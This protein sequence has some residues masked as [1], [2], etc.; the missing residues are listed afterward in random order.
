[1]PRK[2]LEGHSQKEQLFQLGQLIKQS[3]EAEG[4]TLWELAL[5]NR[6]T[7]PMNDALGVDRL[8]EGA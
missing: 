3:R 1:M 8:P 2:W 7:T 4:G 5:E 6:I